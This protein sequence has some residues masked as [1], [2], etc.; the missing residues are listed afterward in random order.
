MSLLLQSEM[1]S[2]YTYIL[3]IIEH[4]TIWGNFLFDSYVFRKYIFSALL[5]FSKSFSKIKFKNRGCNSLVLGKLLLLTKYSWSI[6]S[7]LNIG[8]T[9]NRHALPHFARFIYRL[10]VFCGLNNT[11]GLSMGEGNKRTSF[12]AS[13]GWKSNGPQF[14]F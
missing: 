4:W 6:Y 10:L 14:F 1:G 8:L 2:W 7:E 9:V 5:F 3:I 12:H 11:K 13:N